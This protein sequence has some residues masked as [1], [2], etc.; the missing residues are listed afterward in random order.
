MT[1]LNE[2]VMADDICFSR[3]DVDA[4][5]RHYEFP[6]SL[7]TPCN[8]IT[9]TSE[10]EGADM[11]RRLIAENAAA[12]VERIETRIVSSVV[13]L[14]SVAMVT[15]EKTRIGPDGARKGNYLSTY[16]GHRSPDGWKITA[17]AIDDR[18][19]RKDGRCHHTSFVKDKS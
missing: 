6:M 7:L 1:S 13:H 11:L 5:V 19:W 2:I 8:E 3:G 4:S 17:L 16:A 15:A 9:I 18:G 14:D 12:G 10:E